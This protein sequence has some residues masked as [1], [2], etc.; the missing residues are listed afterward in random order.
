M[1]TL[2]LLVALFALQ[3]LTAQEAYAGPYAD[4]LSKC[5]V[6]STSTRDRTDLVRWM[7]TAAA[8]H[9]AVK[10]ISNVTDEQVDDANKV[11]ADLVTELLTESCRTETEKALQYEGASTLETSFMILGQVAGQ[12]LFASPE[13]AAGLAGL[14]K[15]LD[16]EKLGSL[17]GLQ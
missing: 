7:F 3:S 13:V 5:L 10:P 15:H 4:E 9:P 14:E 12:E 8:L 11:I 1:K 6:E 17:K 16:E 2:T